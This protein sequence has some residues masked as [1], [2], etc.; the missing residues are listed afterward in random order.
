MRRLSEDDLEIVGFL[1]RKPPSR[2][3]ATK[4]VPK[5]T[6]ST[7]GPKTPPLTRQGASPGAAFHFGL[8][9]PS[10]LLRS[11]NDTSKTPRNTSKTPRRTKN[12][13]SGNSTTRSYAKLVK[14]LDPST[15][16]TNKRLT[17]SPHTKEL[18]KD[19]YRKLRAKAKISVEIA[20]NYAEDSLD[21]LPSKAHWRVYKELADIARRQYVFSRSIS[22]SHP[23]SPI[24][25]SSRHDYEEARAMFTRVNELQPYAAAGWIE[26]AKM[27]EDHGDDESCALLLAKGLKSC[28]FNETLLIQILKL[29]IVKLLVFPETP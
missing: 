18:L 25:N 14:V 26:H 23:S 21:S 5:S 19:F 3:T 28:R 2:P 6:R 11:S 4:G 16:H 13:T 24:G 15:T 7:P 20:K 1:D 8:N 22:L 27:V 17:D 10:M 29:L 12:K 9:G